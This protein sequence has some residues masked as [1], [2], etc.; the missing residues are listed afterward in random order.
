VSG[1]SLIGLLLCGIMPANPAEDSEVSAPVVRFATF[2]ASLNRDKAGELLRDLGTPTNVQARNVAEIIQRAKPDVLLVN[3]FDF[4]PE[5]RAAELFQTNYLAIS[6]NGAEAITY[7]YRYSAEVNTG[8]ASGFDLDGNGQVAREPGSRGYGND[9]FGFGLFPGQYGMVLYSKYPIDRE[10]V[11]QFGK[12]LWKAMPGA[13]L[14]TKPE[15]SPWYSADA[16]GAFRLSSKSH[17]DIPVKIGGKVVHVLAS[18]PTPPAFDG[19]EDR[20]GKR[21]HDEIRLWADYLSGGEKAAYL[22]TNGPATFVLLGDMNADPVDGGSVPGAIQQLLDHPAVDSSFVPTSR[23]A[24]EA[25]SLQKG[26]NSAQKGKPEADTA[27]FDDR[28]VGNLRADYVLPSKDLK[29][30]AGGVFWPEASDPLARLVKMTPVV[31]SSDHRLVY[32]DLA[33]D[34]GTP[35]Q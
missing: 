26:A 3:E 13:L 10:G 23:G 1:T 34:E 31:A 19:P 32:L 25:S 4:D 16:L 9:A 18:H 27:D 15:G 30:K 5:G 17:W 29:V 33:I 11:R 7:P 22:G 21:N 12:V 35:K 20:N 14:P 8:V 28:S 2:N 24:A 6:Q